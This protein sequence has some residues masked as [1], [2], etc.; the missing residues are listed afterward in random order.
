MIVIYMPDGVIY[1]GK[2]HP[3][4]DPLQLTPGEPLTGE[5]FPLLAQA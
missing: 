2:R 5:L 3:V 1:T 4:T